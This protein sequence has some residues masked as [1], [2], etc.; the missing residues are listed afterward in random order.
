MTPSQPE[1]TDSS[2]AV[3]V[4]LARLAPLVG[5]AFGPIAIASDSHWA[6]SCLSGALFGLSF[7][8]AIWKDLNV[9]PASTAAGVGCAVSLLFALLVAAVFIWHATLG[10]YVIVSMLFMGALWALTRS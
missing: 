2:S 9:P 10:T 8:F 6:W 7:S 1:T 4:W 5:L 3:L